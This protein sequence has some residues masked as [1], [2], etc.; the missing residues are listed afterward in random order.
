MYQLVIAFTVVMI[1]G[2]SFDSKI[3][4]DDFRS[5]QD[6]ML[7]VERTVASMQGGKGVLRVDVNDEQ[8]GCKRVVTIQG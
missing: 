8:T 2:H 6:C 4:G 7:Q 5:Y 3:V 1:N